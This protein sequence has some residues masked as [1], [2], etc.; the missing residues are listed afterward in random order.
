[1]SSDLHG[2]CAIF[3]PDFNHIWIFSTQIP[4]VATRIKLHRNPSTG[5]HAGTYRRMDA[6]DELKTCSS[7]LCELDYKNN[8]IV[9]YV[10]QPVP[11]R[12]PTSNTTTP[13]KKKSQNK[14][15]F[16]HMTCTCQSR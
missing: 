11:I 2:K 13:S 10:Q 5:T 15:K 9:S 1:M 3:L 16:Y 4:I 8:K 7:Q 14:H 12:Y 6:H